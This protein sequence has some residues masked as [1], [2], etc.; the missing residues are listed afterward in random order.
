MINRHELRTRI[1]EIIVTD[2]GFVDRLL[3]HVICMMQPSIQ[4]ALANAS[5]WIFHGEY[6]DRVI[7]ISLQSD[8]MTTKHR[9]YLPVFCERIRDNSGIGH[10]R[11][12]CADRPLAVLRYSPA[13]G[14]W[15]QDQETATVN[16]N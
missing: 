14:R 4:P 10:V 9:L 12:M 6:N 5:A 13:M 8:A 15:Y 7:V 2:P 16:A 11:I 3:L 1:N